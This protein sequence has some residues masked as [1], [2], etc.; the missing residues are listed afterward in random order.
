MTNHVQHVAKRQKQQDSFW[1]YDHYQRSFCPPE[2]ALLITCDEA[3]HDRKLHNVAHKLA[4][5]L[6][7]H[8][9]I[10][11]ART[12]THIHEDKRTHTLT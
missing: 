3:W 5:K 12:P 1:L 2:I 7:T 10:Y 6:S 11:V 9:K 8:A 4:I